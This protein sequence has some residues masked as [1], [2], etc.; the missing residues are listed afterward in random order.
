MINQKTND[1]ATIEILLSPQEGKGLPKDKP[2]GLIEIQRVLKGIEEIKFSYFTEKDVVR[3]RLV[4][5]IIKAYEKLQKR[6]TKNK[7]IN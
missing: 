5:Q 7:N 4:Q 1:L 3:H 6:H 2:S